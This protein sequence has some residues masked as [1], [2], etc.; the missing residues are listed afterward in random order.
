MVV[1]CW[2]SVMM[3]MFALPLTETSSLAW[4]HI[5]HRARGFVFLLLF[6]FFKIENFLVPTEFFSKT[7]DA[8]RF[9]AILLAFFISSLHMTWPTIHKNPKPNSSHL[10]Y[11]TPCTRAVISVN[12]CLRKLEKQ[13]SVRDVVWQL[14]S[15][16]R[17]QAIHLCCSVES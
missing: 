17:I 5:I 16:D 3:R 2:R 15:L 13:V 6:S 9:S 12:I 11:K 4:L 14:A 10:P 7:A 8:K 1:Y